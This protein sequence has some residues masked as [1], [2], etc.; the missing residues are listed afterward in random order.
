MRRD[1]PRR[2]MRARTLL[3][4]LLLLSLVACD[5]TP[6]EPELDTTVMVGPL[7]LA[8]SS[9]S[10]GANPAGALHIEVNSDLVRMEGVHITELARGGRLPEAETGAAGYTTLRDAIRAAPSR[11]ILALTLH[12]VVPYGTTV[13]VVQA[14]LEAGYRTISFAVRPPN[15]PS[16]TTTGWLELTAPRV[17]GAGDDVAFMPARSW[18]DFSTHWQEVYEG[19]RAAAPNYVDCS[20]PPALAAPGGD[21]QMIL[22]TR[23]NG[24][25]VRFSQVNA[26]DAGPAGGG[27]GGGPA[28]LEG[29]ARVDPR[30]GEEEPPTPVTTGAFSFRFIEASLADN[31][32]SMMARPV[33]GSAACPLIVEADEETETMRVL[34]LLGSVSPNGATSPNVVFRLPE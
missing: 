4:S 19:C 5:D 7:E 9:R 18:D 20:G 6:P 33:C 8:I 3:A 23:G 10:D 29:L 11:A 13:R 15:A 2:L 21:L 1:Y 34:S 12:G 27:G 25:M 31:H 24:M 26:P 32:I 28:L 30:A 17:V 14:A 16:P 22:F